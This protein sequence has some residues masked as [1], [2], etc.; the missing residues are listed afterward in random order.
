[1]AI[2]RIGS[3][4]VGTLLLQGPT[5]TTARRGQGGERTERTERNADALRVE[6]SPAARRGAAER[7]VTQANTEAAASTAWF[8]SPAGSQALGSLARR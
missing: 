5:T 6:L 2:D 4:Q 1:M 7:A 8:A 3:Q